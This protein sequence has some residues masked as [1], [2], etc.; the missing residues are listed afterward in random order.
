MRSEI[1]DS[2]LS[3]GSEIVGARVVHSIIGVR[4][5]VREGTLLDEV[6]MLGAD[7]FDSDDMMR[8]RP[9][10]DDSLPA[11]GIGRNCVIERAII[12]KNAR[13]GDNVIIRNKAAVQKLEGKN[14]WIQ[15]SITVIPK[16]AV[17][18]A[19]TEI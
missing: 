9:R 14:Y 17:I 5:N 12:D 16:N 18:P 4:S 13:I 8:D 6:V 19:G 1:R 11:L 2:I 7:F 10:K 3:D 15:D